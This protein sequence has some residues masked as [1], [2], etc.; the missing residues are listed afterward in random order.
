MRIP[1]LTGSTGPADV[2]RGEPVTFGVPLPRGGAFSTENWML[3]DPQGPQ[4]VQVRALDLWRDGSIRW[5]LVDASL[6]RGPSGPDALLLEHDVGVSGE[7]GHSRP[8]HPRSGREGTSDLHSRPDSLSISEESGLIVVDT[9]KARIALGTGG[10]IPLKEVVIAGTPVIDPAASGLCVTLHDGS[11]ADVMFDTVTVEERGPRR[12]VILATGTVNGRSIRRQLLLTTRLHVYAGLPTVKVQVALTNP[13]RA[14]HQGGFW[15]LGDAGSVL[16]KDV[17]LKI[18]LAQPHPTILCSPEV[19]TAQVPLDAPVELYQDSS[20]GE[21]WRSTNHITR[22]REVALGFRGYRL[23][24]GG[25]TRHGLRATPLLSVERPGSQVTLAVPLFWQNFPKALE[26]DASAVTLRLFPGQSADVHEIQGGEQKTHELFVSFAPDPVTATPLDWCR[27]RTVVCAEPAWTLSSGAVPL[28]API[29]EDHGALVNAAIEGAD[30][31]ERKREVVDEYGW[32]HFGDVYG[33]HE[34]VRHKG[35][36]PLVSH[37]NNQ[38]D[39]VAGFI[40]QFLRTADLRW[41]LLATELTAHVIDIDVYHTTRDKWAY[42]GGLFWHTYHY[43]DAD[44]ATHRTYPKSAHGKTHG[45]GPSADH[46]YTTGLMLHYFLTGDEASR[47]TAIDLA[48]YVVN[49]DDGRKTVL[50]WLD[51][52]DTGGATASADGGRYHGPGRGAANSLNALIDGHRLT[53]DARL[54]EKAEHLIRRV[55]HPRDDIAARHL[56]EP[57]RRW[58]YTMFLQSLGKYLVSKAERG[59]LDAMHGYARTSLL[60]YAR[61]MADH[62][63]PYLEKPEKL[64]FPTETWAAQEIRKSDVFYLAALHTDERERA[65]FVERGAFFFRTAVDTLMR[66]PT[67]TLARPVIILLS[68]GLLHSWIQQHPEAKADWSE[69]VPDFGEPQAFVPQKQRAKQRLKMIGAGALGLLLVLLLVL[70]ALAG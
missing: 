66:M 39:T 59:E 8:P 46:N 43:G 6:D 68:S 21:N 38:Y 69:Q 31:F 24:A 19:D 11:P 35:P 22:N 54:L 15:D 26:A 65:R 27:R 45:G 30:T 18:A 56:D 64:E 25:E 2:R 23:R 14:R 13:E 48:R 37:Y 61:W 5:L 12:S 67:R 1:L 28:L 32:R 20:G 29:G 70:A 7:A 41:W 34:G 33:D 55:I 16:L 50:R 44:T 4:T 42:N 17:S 57:E 3:R 9:G 52:G 10:R 62:E 58:F 53:A 49:I 40:Y 60:H 47:Q 36:M 63:Y 51:A